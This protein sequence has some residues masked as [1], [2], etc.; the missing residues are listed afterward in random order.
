MPWLAIGANALGSLASCLMVP[1]MMTT[2]YNL[3]KASPC[4]LRFHI[5]TEGGWDA[6]C[7][8]CCLIAAAL[9]AYGTHLSIL[10]AL[11]FPGLAVSTILLRRYYA[12]SGAPIEPVPL[13]LVPPGINSL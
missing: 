1:A 3:A 7:A 9:A 10:L 11:G 4:A 13:P 5:A 6:G 12:A 8:T 2:V